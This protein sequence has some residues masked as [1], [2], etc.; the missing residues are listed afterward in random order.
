MT[1]QQQQTSLLAGLLV[2]CV[3]VYARAM[4]R[5]ASHA[6]GR[7]VGSVSAAA[8]AAPAVPEAH[9]PF[10]AHRHAQR[11]QAKLLA[12]SRDPFLRGSSASVTGLSLSGIIWDPSHP[13]AI[14]NGVP[15]GIG[16]EIEGFRVLEILEDRVTLTDNT[17]TYSLRM[18]P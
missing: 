3:V 12:W 16:E 5:P 18:T 17:Q 2:I 11:E 8:P 6:A 7:A 13:L 9:P 10:S 4:K 14:I 1:R 15:L